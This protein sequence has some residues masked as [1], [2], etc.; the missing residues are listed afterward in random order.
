[1]NLKDFMNK[2]GVLFL[3]QA[4]NKTGILETLIDTAVSTGKIRDREGFRQAVLDR[5]SLVST[6]IGLGIAIPHSKLA[7]IQE[8]FIILGLCPRGID[9]DSLDKK[10]V[11]AVFLIGGPA[12]RQRDYLQILAKLTLFVKNEKRLSELFTSQDKDRIL[13]L[14]EG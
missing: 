4:E 3:D 7:G 14:F 11:K 8:F 13:A 12:D 2:D 5:E 9:W 1:M 6:G 10:P